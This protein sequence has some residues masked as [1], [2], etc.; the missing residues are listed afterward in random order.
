MSA[1][2][3]IAMSIKFRM[4]FIL[5][6]PECQK[7][8]IGPDATMLRKLVR[9]RNCRPVLR[10]I[11]ESLL[12]YLTHDLPHWT[13]T[14]RDVKKPVL[15][16]VNESTTRKTDCPVQ[17]ELW[18]SHEAISQLP[19]EH[20]IPG[21]C[22]SHQQKKMLPRVCRGDKGS[23][24]LIPRRL[25]T[26]QLLH[27]KFIRSKP[28][29]HIP[30]QRE[31]GPLSP[32]RGVAGDDKPDSEHEMH[33]RGRDRREPGLK[34]GNSVKHIVAKFAAVEL[35]G[36]GENHMKQQPIKPRLIG[37]GILLSSLMEKF[38]TMATV[39][40]GNNERPR[41]GV[42]VTS[43]VKLKV[44][45]ER[46]CKQA[47]NK[48]DH[49]PNQQDRMKKKCAKEQLEEN[50][51]T[52][53]EEQ[54]P[55]QQVDVPTIADSNL[56]DRKTV[57][58]G[59]TQH[60]TSAHEDGDYCSLHNLKGQAYAN[61]VKSC[62]SG[63]HGKTQTEFVTDKFKYGHLERLCFSCVTEWSLPQPYRLVLHG[64]APVR[65]HVANM[66][67]RSPVWSKCVDSSPKQYLKRHTVE[68]SGSLNLE[69]MGGE[70][71][72]A[73]KQ[74]VDTDDSLMYNRVV[75][76]PLRPTATNQ[77]RL[78]H[79]VI[80]RVHRFDTQQ[81]ADQ[82]CSS[83][84]SAQHPEA[85]TLLDAMPPSQSDSSTTSFNTA[86]MV[87]G[88]SQ[89]IA[90]YPLDVRVQSA[91]SV[92]ENEEADGKLEQVYQTDVEGKED[93]LTAVDKRCTGVQQGFRLSEASA[94]IHMFDD[95]MTPAVTLP[96]N[97]QLQADNSKQRPK[98]TTI[99]YGDPSVKQIYK[100]K[101]IRFTDTFTF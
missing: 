77:S 75:K 81:G 91:C 53:G 51:T 99:N 101:I 52:D 24:D 66:Q 40:K 3:E 93:T 6:R 32:S 4:S 37:R 46:E 39:C 54:R 36:K 49:K 42:K 84:Q 74:S 48:T 13:T 26:F 89:D 5:H 73:V 11:L 44:G 43:F 76:D 88:S 8:S 59:Q 47:V 1:P 68:T 17:A 95:K 67:P 20:K 80:P 29:P 82:T 98:Y 25:T 30:H 62:S 61:D 85:E 16:T 92:T 10:G 100:P 57:E 79:H 71:G 28:K 63:E 14:S 55:Q 60:Q 35:K 83:R 12:H 70:G 86:V 58:V 19:E 18:A 22:L 96:D 50:P 97:V 38:E 41:E 78:P 7:A 31:V 87:K 65:W 2:L 23:E 34:R 45:H 9:D 27:S 33:K 21:K 64:D 72:C 94:R 56:E 90:M 69:K 15:G